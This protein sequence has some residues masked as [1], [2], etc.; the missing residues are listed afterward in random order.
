M[1]TEKIKTANR[2][3]EPLVV[4]LLDGKKWELDKSFY[5]YLTEDMM[6]RAN[7]SQ[8]DFIIPK[9][10]KTDFASVPKVLRPF[11]KFSDIYNPSS[12]LHDYLY[13]YGS[14]HGISRESADKIFYEALLVAGISKAKA[15]LFYW[16]VR[17]F[18]RNRYKKE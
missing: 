17:M 5:F 13:T 6:K 2:F 12:V 14:K 1:L 3:K 9:G 11:L 7:V 16:S 18:G 10:F 8:K 15:K 4:K